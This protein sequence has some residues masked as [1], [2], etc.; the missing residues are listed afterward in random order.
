MGRIVEQVKSEGVKARVTRHRSRAAAKGSKRVEVSV[1]AGDAPLVKAIA[2]ALR[3]GGSTA[4]HIREAIQPLVAAPKAKTGAELV[5]FFRNSPFVDAE[6]AI[7]R[8]RSGGR[9]V[10]FE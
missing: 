8:D 9:G 5:A 3:E 6:L 1:P 2:G 4:R 7:E 10:D